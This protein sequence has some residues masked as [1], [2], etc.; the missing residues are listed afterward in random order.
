MTMVVTSPLKQTST[1]KWN[2]LVLAGL[3]LLQLPPHFG[4]WY[5]CL[6]EDAMSALCETMNSLIPFSICELVSLISNVRRHETP[7]YVDYLIECRV[8]TCAHTIHRVRVPLSERPAAHRQL[9]PFQ[10]FWTYLITNPGK[11]VS[12]PGPGF[13][14]QRS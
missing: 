4:T 5:L 11:R 12:V 13:Q 14:C 7:E 2:R 6:P 10:E 8:Q 1:G 9:E 3:V